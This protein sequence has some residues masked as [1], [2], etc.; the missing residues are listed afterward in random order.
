MKL[1]VAVHTVLCFFLLTGP[2]LQS[3]A[4]DGIITITA[5][6]SLT[7]SS[8]LFVNPDSP[9]P[10]EQNSF[11]PLENDFGGGVEVKYTFFRMNLAMS[12]SVE[13]LA[14][15][16][17]GQ[18]ASGLPVEDGYQVVPVEITAY[19]IVPISGPELR[20]FMGGGG[21][22]YIGERVYR[23]GGVE[24]P[25]VGSKTGFGIHVLGG[26]SY[27]ITPFFALTGEMKFRDL[28]FDT[29][30]AFKTSHIFYNG[31]VIEVGTEPF[32]SSVHTDG[33]IFNL[34]VAFSF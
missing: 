10:I 20:I 22:A 29:A 26:A 8:Q 17:T 12:M 23:M 25:S 30:N 9:D 14:T 27:N 18:S 13:Y 24:A 15:G 1:N 3:R 34:G 19:F 11:V 32:S 31:R 5:K 16:V 6:A 4:D 2:F 33:V 7:T 21:G 28:Q